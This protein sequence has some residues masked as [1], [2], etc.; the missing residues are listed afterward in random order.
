MAVTIKKLQ[1]ENM[2]LKRDKEN[3][4]ERN[5]AL[6]IALVTCTKLIPPPLSFKEKVC[7]INNRVERNYNLFSFFL[8]VRIGISSKH[9]FY[10]EKETK[11]KKFAPP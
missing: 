7:D 3:L 10:V 6:Q 9:S 2:Q 11:V 8:K 5:D 4:R 1:Q